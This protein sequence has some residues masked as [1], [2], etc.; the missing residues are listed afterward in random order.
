M[1]GKTMVPEDY[2]VDRKDEYGDDMIKI[3]LYT[4]VKLSKD[5]L[6]LLKSENSCHA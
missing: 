5:N 4:H 6:K 1:L 2:E 3:V